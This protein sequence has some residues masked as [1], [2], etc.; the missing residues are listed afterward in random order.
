MLRDTKRTKTKNKTR[1]LVDKN[2]WGGGCNTY[3]GPPEY[4]YDEEFVC[5][6]CGTKEIWTAKQQKMWYEELGKYV[7]ARAI[8]CIK[9]RAHINALKVEHKLHMKEMEEKKPHPNDSFFK[10]KNT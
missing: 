5:C 9:C 1:I 7:Y 8:R 10:N 2:K 6:D 3:A 4:Y